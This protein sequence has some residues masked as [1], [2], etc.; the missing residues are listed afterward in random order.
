MFSFDEEILTIS[1]WFHDCGYSKGYN[2]Y[3]AYNCVMA[4]EF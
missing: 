2:G 4:T 1:A 3:E